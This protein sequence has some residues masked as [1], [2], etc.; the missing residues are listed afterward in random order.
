M[1]GDRVIVQLF[2]AGEIA[3]GLVKGTMPLAQWA[4]GSNS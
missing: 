3:Y 2:R 1:I 4:S